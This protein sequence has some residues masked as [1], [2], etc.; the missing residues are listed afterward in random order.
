MSIIGTLKKAFRFV[1][2]LFGRKKR[3]YLAGPDVFFENAEEHFS[4]LQALCAEHGFIGVPPSDGGLSKGQAGTGPE[5]AERIYRAN[6]ALIRDCD[7]VLANLTPFRNA[8][9]PD[10]GTVFEVGF[11]VAL[12][13]PV[14]G[15][16]PYAEAYYEDKVMHYHGCV[17]KGGLP[18]DVH[19]GYLIESFQQP[20]NLMLSR[21]TAIF[22][23]VG[24]ALA[25]MK[26]KF[27]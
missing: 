7:I 12:G 9:I 25:H 26:L 23:D 20:L 16:L 13:I 1:G 4:Q 21:S 19:Y 15:Y 6:I 14:V 11:A 18:F 17:D 27:K 3:I 22:S 5:I 2:N 24:A 8:T 10:D